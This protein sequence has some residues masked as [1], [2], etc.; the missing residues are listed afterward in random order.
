M[1]KSQLGVPI[2]LLHEAEG[3][4]VNWIA[5]LGGRTA[6]RV[7]AAG[8]RP[9]SAFLCGHGLANHHRVH[10]HHHHRHRVRAS[11]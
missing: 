1:A 8:W 5:R 3:H 7:A 10:H 2:K 9:P 6:G 4:M 11:S